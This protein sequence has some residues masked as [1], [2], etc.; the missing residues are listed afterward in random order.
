[1]I[2]ANHYN[3]Y[4]IL[5]I[6]RTWRKIF[7]GE[8]T[9]YTKPFYAA[10]TMDKRKTPRPQETSTEKRNINLH[11]TRTF[12]LPSLMIYHICGI[13]AFPITRKW[14]IRE[15]R[16]DTARL[17]LGSFFFVERLTFL[18]RYIEHGIYETADFIFSN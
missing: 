10:S 9:F 13:A 11:E 6:M 14:C 3:S 15:T 18:T 17:S 8:N 16:D 5:Q 4:F 12:S 2:F 1:M 7:R